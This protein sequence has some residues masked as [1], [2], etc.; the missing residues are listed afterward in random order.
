MRNHCPYIQPTFSHRLEALQNHL[1]MR[2]TE[3]NAFGRRSRK[4]VPAES[5]RR[6][7]HSLLADLH[8]LTSDNAHMQKLPRV[9]K[10]LAAKLMEN[11]ALMV[12]AILMYVH[13]LYAS[14]H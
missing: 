6:S 9:N 5:G 3:S 12:S 13:K 8:T 4:S 1:R 7:V 2:N 10:E 11:E 14:L